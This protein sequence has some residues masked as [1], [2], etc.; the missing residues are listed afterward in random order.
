MTIN[1]RVI[2]MS[3]LFVLL[4]TTLIGYAQWA[5]PFKMEIIP[6]YAD[7]P[8]ITN[9]FNHK[10]YTTLSINGVKAKGSEDLPLLGVVIHINGE[11]DPANFD[12]VIAVN[13]TLNLS[14]CN[15]YHGNTISVS[16]YTILQKDNQFG[17]GDIPQIENRY[18]DCRWDGKTSR[19]ENTN[20]NNPNRLPAG[21]RVQAVDSIKFNKICTYDIMITGNDPL[22]DQKILET[23]CNSGY[24]GELTRDEENPDIIVTVSKNA[25]E[26]FSSTYVPPTTQVVNAGSITRPVYNYITRRTSYVTTQQNQYI[27]SGGYNQD[28]LNTNIFLEFTILDA[29]KIN[30]PKQSTPPII[31]QM[32]YN[33][34]VTN[35]N[36]EVIDE[37]MAIATW[38]CFPFTFNPLVRVPKNFYLGCLMEGKKVITEPIPGSRAAII[39]LR[40]GDIVKDFKGTEVRTMWGTT[41]WVKR[42]EK[43]P[44]NRGIAW[45]YPY[46]AMFYAEKIKWTKEK[47]LYNDPGF[48]LRNYYSEGK[49]YEFKKLKVY[50]NGKE[51]KINGELDSPLLDCAGYSAGVETDINFYWIFN[52]P[53]KR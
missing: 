32:T 39:G 6:E 30:D 36:Y 51:I 2:K 37:Y 4:E 15:S 5:P 26:T 22:T 42:K 24:F 21:I 44:K 33:R 47:A 38:N 52:R 9:T 16:E 12:H 41:D 1:N 18:I 20:A 3:F 8:V 11:S 29:K 34:N 49:W 23:F 28:N 46:M 13:D 53:Y 7:F 48:I 10:F 31:W 25:N 14:I 19:G 43:Y 35:R 40:M 17:W 45:A 50:R 27:Q